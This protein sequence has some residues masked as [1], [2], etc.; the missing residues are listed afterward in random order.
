MV[1]F[2]LTQE[3]CAQTCSSFS[4]TFPKPPAPFHFSPL[5]PVAHKGNRSEETKVSIL[6][7]SFSSAHCE[8]RHAAC[9]N[10]TSV[11]PISTSPCDSPLV[12]GRPNPRWKGPSAE[13]GPSLLL[14]L[15]KSSKCFLCH[16]AN[17]DD[18]YWPDSVRL[19]HLRPQEKPAVT[20]TAREPETTW[21]IASVFRHSNHSK[22][23]KYC[24]QTHKRCECSVHFTF[25][26]VFRKQ[27]CL[28]FTC[29]Q[30]V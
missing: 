18:S 27:W 6:F 28:K 11:L 3:C 24:T 5:K 29:S 15:D 8:S 26:R 9:H 4:V 10:A 14:R 22:E 30:P 16:L 23:R 13:E 12:P 7:L 17:K 2:W 25:S 19:N 1:K 20:R 21:V